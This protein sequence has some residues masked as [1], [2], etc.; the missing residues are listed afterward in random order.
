MSSLLRPK[1]TKV[2][3]SLPFTCN[4]LN[5]SDIINRKQRFWQE[6]EI[7]DAHDMWEI[8]G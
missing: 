3:F 5:D 8:D 2:C 6:K 4:S 1:S 7:L